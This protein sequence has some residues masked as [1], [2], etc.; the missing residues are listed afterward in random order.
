[1]LSIQGKNL[2]LSGRHLYNLYIISFLLFENTTKVENLNK[3][4][5]SLKSNKNYSF[6]ISLLPVS[7]PI[8]FNFYSETAAQQIAKMT[9][10]ELYCFDFDATLTTHRGQALTHN[11]NFFFKEDALEALLELAKER[12][13][14]ITTNNVNNLRGF[15]QENEQFK[16]MLD[17]DQK[18][19]FERMV[20]VHKSSKQSTG[21]PKVPLITAILDLFV[22]KNQKA[23]LYFTDDQKEYCS[24]VQQM[25]DDRIQEQPI[26]YVQAQ[27]GGNL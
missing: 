27:G 16:N 7:L 1:M 20:I 26:V 23:K 25:Q 24:S 18:L 4:G 5:F 8:L 6:P 19:L 11:E 15:I 21:G 9:I 10:N 14:F 17:I 3:T 13:F 2:I 12:P 22:E